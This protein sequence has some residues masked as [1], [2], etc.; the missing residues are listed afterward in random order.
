MRAE[1]IEEIIRQ[2]LPEL[3]KTYTIRQLS[4]RTNFSYDSTYRH[5]Q[6]LFNTGILART[7]VGKSV[8]CGLNMRSPD[9][10][11][12]VEKISLRI[13]DDFL[14]KNRG[15]KKLLNEIIER[16]ER[17]IPDQIFSIILY[18]SHAK[19]TATEKSDIDILFLVS[20]LSSKDTINKICTEVSYRYGREIAPLVSNVTE[21]SKMLASET[22]TVGHEILIDGLVLYGSEKYYTT[23]F[24]VLGR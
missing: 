10:R 8:V 21:F 15:L 23:V 24:R 1:T 20:D 4:M 3:N 22:H 19:E 14:L 6:Y 7:R 5:I 16:V 12:L 13:A 17:T 2:Y 11:K 18:G 9:A